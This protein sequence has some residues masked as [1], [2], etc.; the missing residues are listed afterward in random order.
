MKSLPNSLPGLSVV[1]LAG[2][3]GLAAPAQGTDAVPGFTLEPLSQSVASGETVFFDV[4]ASG[5]APLSYQW[6]ING[7]NLSLATNSSLTITNVQPRHWGNYTVVAANSLGAAT[8]SVASLVVDADLVFRIL[9][10][11]TNSSVAVEHNRITGDDRGGIAVSADNVFVTGDGTGSSVVT[12][13]F[14][15]DNLGGGTALTQG[16]D[17]LTSNLRTETVYTLGDGANPIQYANFSLS[18]NSVNSLIEINGA[19]G[20]LTGQRINL[21]TNIPISTSSGIFAGFDRVVI[22]SGANSRVYDIRLPSGVVTDLGSIGF[23]SKQG[24]ES[25]AFWG[26]VEYF[27]GSL[28][29]L[30][31]Q[32]G[33]IGDV[34]GSGIARTR[35]ADRTTTFLL[36]P[37]PSPGLSDMASFTFS[38]SRSRWL[39]HHEGTSIFRSSGNPDETVGSA[40]A[41][42]TTDAGYPAILLEPLDQVSYPS[43]NVVFRTVASGA[44][45]FTYQ[46]MFNGSPIP[47]ATASS[48]NL[49]DIDT[50]AMGAYSV[51]VS[52][53]VGITLSRG[54]LLTIYSAPQVV[55][56]P[57]SISAFA[58][59]NVFLSISLNAAP[60]IS[61]QWRFN[62]AV[63]VGATNYF[64]LLTNVQPAQSGFYTVAVSNRFG[65]LLSSNAELNVVVPV[66][67]GSVFQI[68]NLTTNGLRSTNVYQFPLDFD[69]GEGPLAVSSTQVFY[70]DIA[71]TARNSA[72]DLSGG[73]MIGRLYAALL[74]NLR[75]ETVYALGN[76]GGPFDYESGRATRLWE[77][78]GA[79]GTLTGARINLSTAIDLPPQSSQVGFFSGYD[80]IVILTG[81]RAY[82]I[83]LPSGNVTDLGPMTTPSHAF[84]Q[85][86][87]FWGVA[88]HAGGIIYL[89]YGRSDGRNIARTRVP[90]G[91]TTNFVTFPSIGS[92]MASI[93]ASISR[94]RWYYQ[95]LFGNTTFGS[96]TVVI[97]YASA[98]FTN[99]PGSKADRFVWEPIGPIQSENAPFTATLT[100]RNAANAIATNFDG[101]VT[102]S[103]LATPASTTVPI[104][105]TSISGFVNGIWT[106]Q[107]TIQQASTG[108]VLRAFDAN[109]VTGTSTVFSVSPPNDLVVTVMD[110]PAPVVIGQLLRYTIAVTNTGPTD[111][112]TVTLT[113]LLPANFA[114]QSLT[115]STGVC[116]IE[117]KLVSCDLGTVGVGTVAHVIIVGVPEAAGT[118]TNQTFIARGETDSEP[119]NNYAVTRTA[120]VLPALVI[121]DISSLEG[122]VGTNLVLFTVRLQAP[123]ANTVS[124]NYQTLNNS[125]SGTGG[126]ADYVPAS[127]TVIFPPGTTSRTIAVG[128]RGDPYYEFNEVFFVSLSGATNASIAD[129]QGSCTVQNDD[130]IPSVSVADV[131]VTEGNT[132]ITNAI[133]QVRLSAIPALPVYV[134]YSTA[135]GSAQPGTDFIATN[136]FIIFPP[137]Q[138]QLTRS[139]IVPVRGDTNLE[140]SEFFRLLINPTN[141]TSV[142]T[143]ALCTILTD[144]GQGVLHHFT[145]SSIE[146][147]QQL[148]TAFN[149]TIHA[150]DTFNN[151]VTNFTGTAAL[152]GGT[153]ATPTNIF[154]GADFSD[155]FDGDYTL[156]FSFTPKVD[157]TVTHFRHYTG[158]KVSLWTDA[159]VVLA[160]QTVSSSPGTWLETA[161]DSPV[162]LTAGATYVLA[163][164]TGVTQYYFRGESETDFTDV[165][166]LSG[167]YQSGDRF[168]DLDPQT[169]GWAVDLRYTVGDIAVPVAI[170]P[171][172]TGN[173]VNGE[174][175]G[176]I[177]ILTTATNA[178]LLATDSGGRSGSSTPFDVLEVVDSDVWLE[179]RDFPTAIPEGSNLTYTVVVQNRGPGGAAD[180][181]LTNLLPDSFVLISATSNQGTSAGLEHL[182]TANLGMLS[183]RASTTIIVV[184]RPEEAGVYTNRAF[185]A[186]GGLD[187]APGN[188]RASAVITVYRDTDG[189][190]MWDSWETQYGL[191]PEDA[192]DANQD[193][194]A[195]GHSN[196]DE[197][198]AGTDPTDPG[199]I[200][201]ILRIDTTN[202]VRITVQC[203]RGRT[204]L[205]ERQDPATE[206]WSTVLL[207]RIGSSI[208]A[209]DTVEVQDPSPSTGPTQLYR[210]RVVPR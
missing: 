134:T 116:A 23:I 144:D 39:F 101:I 173:F 136:G 149:V 31:A 36:G 139:I 151:T 114:F 141:A 126:L 120:A 88:E 1:A 27:A 193:A 100:A 87:S 103:G 185:A 65:S 38:V 152:T 55:A 45:P 184:V 131:S 15:I 82:N 5:A 210:V 21:S 30:Y 52:N 166:L 186:S 98:T 93:T 133:F 60:P 13:R 157:I 195:D 48:L 94:G 9:G 189:D 16:F 154:G 34:F 51:E 147:P 110:D 115:N 72:G 11:Q 80:R 208:H 49:S 127:G 190:G 3:L 124:V 183:N 168:P 161:L 200:T 19:T 25:W 74:S 37:I 182:V 119:A 26:V 207:F 90:D 70:S 75:T 198:L 170:M 81:A 204:Y 96:G 197:F 187:P 17:A 172:N 67:D 143:Q 8:S 61:Y 180:V 77:I 47:G 68:S 85:S 153:G 179:F 57:R 79:N 117:G 62:G 107:I 181:T 105:P 178:I 95:Y 29:L 18:A 59:T 129:N 123:A 10:L 32:N 99:N 71:D 192:S 14:P 64:L 140:P 159:G 104:S 165:T 175:S 128:I 125:A 196:Y 146:S 33:F 108:M 111:A 28:H 53:P 155:S 78:N 92:Y 22:Y 137:G 122:D 69:Y 202:G 135:G 91:V 109:G 164:Y 102:L 206:S 66:D 86:G 148:G 150:Q 4:A 83:S 54:A 132:G 56:Q 106:G 63:V 162:K 167:R 24:S 43:S 121:D 46:W 130:P 138:S 142:N 113:N 160:T 118:L 163:Y 12:G 203:A 44:E 171:T 194:D 145:W 97:G 156:G 41:S 7:T 73:V 76:V 169:T 84:S 209:A 112:T 58:G 40:K 35:V 191:R 2:I 6:R 42:F 188:N 177:T 89:V 201:R 174:W 176:A 158:T 20:Q 199:S 50:N 205:L